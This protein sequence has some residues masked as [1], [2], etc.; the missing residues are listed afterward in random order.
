MMLAALV[1]DFAALGG[2]EVASVRDGR[3]GNVDLPA[4]FRVVAAQEDPWTVWRSAIEAVDAVWPIAPETGGALRRL[5]ELVLATGRT[6]IGSRP[7]GGALAGS[8]CGTA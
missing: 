7:P 3:L 5:G 8:K 6:L 1:K 2:I 4:A